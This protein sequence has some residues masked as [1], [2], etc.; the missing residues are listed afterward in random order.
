MWAQIEKASLF[1]NFFTITMS[2]IFSYRDIECCGKN[3]KSDVSI[4]VVNYALDSFFAIN[5]EA[6][7]N[8]FHSF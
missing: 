8:R 5:F 1:V 3:C 6:L 2:V 7:A 4:R